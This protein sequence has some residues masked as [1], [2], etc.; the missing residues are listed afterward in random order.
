MFQVGIFQALN[1]AILSVLYIP[2]IAQVPTGSFRLA[3]SRVASV[4]WQH[5]THEHPFPGSTFNA[6]Y[7]P[8]MREK[9]LTAQCL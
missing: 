5:D 7:H 9:H 1:K 6:F 4:K 2:E 8:Q 3:V